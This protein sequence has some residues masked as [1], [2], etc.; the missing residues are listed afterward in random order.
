V[1]AG[2]AQPDAPAALLGPLLAPGA[3]ARVPPQLRSRIAGLLL[4]ARAPRSGPGHL[5]GNMVLQPSGQLA[6]LKAQLQHHQTFSFG[7][8]RKCLQRAF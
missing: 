4:Q 8:Q 5:E 7:G 1:A 3:H 6:H 2:G